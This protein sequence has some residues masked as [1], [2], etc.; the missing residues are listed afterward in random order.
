MLSFFTSVNPIFSDELDD[1]NK[2]INE[3]QSALDQSKKATAPLESQLTSMKNQLNAIIV[4][5][6]FI[7]NDI[8]VKRK[9]IND[10]YKNLAT[11][12]LILNKSIRD[13]Y[14][15]GYAFSPLSA[16]IASSN[17][18]SATRILAYQKKGRDKEKSTITTLALSIGGLEENKAKL[19]N[20]EK[21]LSSIKDRLATE[22]V[23]L[24]KIVTG[25][26]N[27]QS[28]LSGEIAQLSAKQQQILAAKNSNFTASIGD[29]ELSDDYQASIKGF[30]ENAPSGSFAVF[31]FGAYTHRNGMSQY[32]ALGRFNSGKNTDAESILK[33]YYP[34]AT[35][36]RDYSVPGSI[37]VSGFG[38]RAFEDQYM[39]RIY[40]V[41][42]S[43]PKEVLK[44]QAVAARTYALRYTNNG[45]P[46][47]PICAN[48][49]CQVY[50][51]SNK[52]GSWEEAASE[53][54]NW[55]LV[56]GGGNLV[57]TQFS[58]T[59]GG[60][61][62]TSGWDTTDGAGG[63]TFIDKSYEKIGGSP[64]LYKAWYREG[65]SNQGATCGRS[66]PWLTGEELS[67]IVNAAIVLA[68]GTS[69]EVERVTPVTT[70]CWGGN[71][72]SMSD[73]RNVAGKYGGIS[74]A[75]D[76][77]VSQ[78]NG[79]TSEVRIGGVSLSGRDFQKAFNLRAAGYTRIPQFGFAFFN[80]EKK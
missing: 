23:S 6:N 74:T 32:G 68:K 24:E 29:S 46:D 34:N 53:T 8:V 22:R 79:S 59:A 4:Q 64:W 26:K 9:N 54:K 12:Q 60:W 3:L 67:D 78:G 72:Y 1:L 30:R 14:I 20:E 76:V 37:T 44:A 66:S 39:K 75:G 2:K 51:D 58:S 25:A 57:S 63:G 31:S 62:N 43:W 7:E 18:A 55:V 40:E 52:G 48:E 71:P 17:A 10:G 19:E 11:K 35:L 69:S 65:Y 36:K 80:I 50:K 27:Y 47:K 13:L 42:G 15:K 73:L 77:I 45:S 56:D 28:K 21:R 5:V 70:S 16:F 61:S 49:G 41:P 38:T 33:F